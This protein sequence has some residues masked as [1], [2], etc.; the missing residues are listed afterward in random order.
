MEEPQISEEFAKD[1]LRACYALDARF[2]EIESVSLNTVDGAETDKLKAVSSSLVTLVGARILVPI[3][4]QRPNF[5]A[6]Y[7]TRILV[8]PRSNA[9]EI[10]HALLIALA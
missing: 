8:T 3:Y 9:S 2:A 4:Q 1:I 7:G 10:R 6:S 5:G